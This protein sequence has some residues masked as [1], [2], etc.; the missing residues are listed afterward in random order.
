[1]R[2]TSM[3]LYKK[4]YVRRGLSLVEVLVAAALVGGALVSVIGAI[5]LGKGAV[6]SAAEKTQAAFLLEDG[7]EAIRILRDK[8]WDNRIANKQV[9]VPYCL[10]FGGGD[11]FNGLPAR[12]VAPKLN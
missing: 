6:T 11:D 9:G 2:D 5:I 1:M 12:E 3:P 4:S 10:D 8:D 7:G